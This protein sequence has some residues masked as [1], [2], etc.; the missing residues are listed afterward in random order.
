MNFVNIQLML[1]NSH[2]QIWDIFDMLY[3]ILINLRKELGIYVY[4]GF[5][6]P[7]IF[8]VSLV[9]PQTLSIHIEKYG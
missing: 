3:I 7:E 2:K 6:M 4:M 1:I 9:N 8:P 5:P